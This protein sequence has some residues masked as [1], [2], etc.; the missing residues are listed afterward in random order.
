MASSTLSYKCSNSYV[1]SDRIRQ[2]DAESGKLE[3]NDRRV[4][5]LGKTYNCILY[6]VRIV[7]FIFNNYKRP[8]IYDSQAQLPQESG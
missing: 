4:L 5:Y 8:A 6:D 1:C 7:G 3:Q 2:Q